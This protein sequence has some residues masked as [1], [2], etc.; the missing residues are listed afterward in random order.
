MKNVSTKQKKNQDQ[1]LWTYHQTDNVN[2]LFSGHPRQDRIFKKINNIIKAGKILEIGFGDGY[3]LQKLT[4][5]YKCYGADISKENIEQMKNKIKNVDFKQV[6]TDGK[7]P[8]KDN[9]FDGFIAS[10]VLEH[11]D[12]KELNKNI[13]EIYRVL[14]PGGKVILTFPADENL[15]DNE[16]FCPN[17]GLNFHK[18]GH[19]QAWSDNKINKIFRRF[20]IIQKK[21]F[22]VPYIGHNKKELFLGKAVWLIR[23]ILNKVIFIEHATY[24]VVLQKNK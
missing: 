4:K 16:C 2:S 11:M 8:Y 10:E 21:K 20:K 18:W 12:D 9:F 7:L 17:C 1:K 23:T 3:L 13:K 24:L 6:N 19:K 22:F 14:K 15:R 5:K